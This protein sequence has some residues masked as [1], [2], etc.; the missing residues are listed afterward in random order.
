MNRRSFFSK[1]P[2]LG[3]AVTTL[4]A[5][6][7]TPLKTE[8]ILTLGSPQCPKCLMIFDC[9]IRIDEQGRYLNWDPKTQE[10]TV[11][12]PKFPMYVEPGCDNSYKKLRFKLP[13]TT[14]EVV[15]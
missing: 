9:S 10:I 7:P 3:A 15:R 14:V 1:L 5:A 4:A 6:D 11:E 12:H 8:Y 13:R 2:L